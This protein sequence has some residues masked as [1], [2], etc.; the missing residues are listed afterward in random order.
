MTNFLSFTGTITMINDFWYPNK[1]GCYKIFTVENNEGL[2]VN[3][4]IEPHT[5]FVDHFTANIGDEIEGYY[6]GD[7]PV[8]LI[9]PPQYRALVINKISP[10]RDVMV[11]YFDENLLSSDKTLKLNISNSTEI[12]L[13]NDQLFTRS[14]QNHDLI[15]IY[16]YVTKSIPAQTTPLKIIVF[17]NHISSS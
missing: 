2:I 17:C 8:A 16:N 5:Y 9:Y 4:I 15:V 3:F 1:E 12:V 6:D 7:V 10:F 11:S 14:L 13:Q